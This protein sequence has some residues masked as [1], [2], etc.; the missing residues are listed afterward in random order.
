VRE[1][2]FTGMGFSSVEKYKNNKLKT[3]KSHSTRICCPHVASRPLIGPKPTLSGLVT[4]L[5]Q[6]FTP[7]VKSIDIKVCLRRMVE[8]SCFSTTTADAIN[9]FTSHSV[10]DNFYCT[11]CEIINPSQSQ[12]IYKSTCVDRAL[13]LSVGAPYLHLQREGM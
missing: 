2:W 6:S 10:G 12:Y 9:T 1:N 4:S 5:T 7:N 8:V 13:G 11:I 3:K